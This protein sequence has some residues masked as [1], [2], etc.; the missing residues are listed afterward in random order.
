MRNHPPIEGPST[1]PVA[2]GFRTD[3]H[4]YSHTHGGRALAV[5][6]SGQGVAQVLP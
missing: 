3:R 4:E 5:L 2:K 6:R 1:D